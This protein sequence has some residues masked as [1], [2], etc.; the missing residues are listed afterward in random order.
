MNVLVLVLI[1]TGTLLFYRIIFTGKSSFFAILVFTLL[2][3][4]QWKTTT[5]VSLSQQGPDQQRIQLQR[6]QLYP[7]TFYKI[8]DVY[9]W[10]YPVKFFEQSKL[11]IVSGRIQH[12]FFEAIDP[13][14]YFFSGHPRQR[15]GFDEFEKFS[16]IFLPVFILGIVRSGKLYSFP[17]LFFLFLPIVF[18]SFIGHRNP[19]GPLIFFPFIAG[20]IGCGLRTL[21]QKTSV[22]WLKI[23][24]LVVIVVV[25]LQTAAYER[26]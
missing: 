21:F 15:V 3:V 24:L 16:Y 9:I 19:Y 25:F 13:S 17:N 26:F 12:N 11:F 4:F 1:I 7:P 8:L 20:S 14:L 22:G 18:I 2:L 23:V 5:I 6:T 10:F